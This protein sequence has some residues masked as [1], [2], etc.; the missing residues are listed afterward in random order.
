MNTART[1]ADAGLRRRVMASASWATGQQAM[2]LMSNIAVSVVLA[3]T[4][5][6]GDFGVISLATTL[7]AF[8]ATVAVGGMSALGIKALVDD[9]DAEASTMTGLILL[10]EGFGLLCYLGVVALSVVGGENRVV[11]ATAVASLVLFARAFDP[12]DFWF[13][14]RLNSRRS[15]TVRIIVTVA[16]LAVRI[17][18]AVLGAG[19]WVFLSLFVLE[20][21]VVTGALL[22]RYL[23]EAES[24][25]FARPN[26]AVAAGMLGGS[27]I[28]LLSGIANQINLRADQLIIQSKL[29]SAAVATY[30]V[31]AR[32]SEMSYFL[33]VVFMTATFPVIIGA[34]K[35]WGGD[36]PKYTALVQRSYDRACWAGIGIAAILF[37]AGPFA[38][39]LL[40]GAR[41]SESGD[42]L[43]IHVLALPFVF[44]AAVYSKWI[45]MENLL[46]ASLLRHALGA[47]LNIALN[48][49]LIPMYGLRGAA[50]ATVISYVVASYLACFVGRPMWPAGVAMTKAFLAP[51]RLL[52]RSLAP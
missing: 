28:L 17:L 22:A 23:T 44:M 37:L 5:P 34:R 7:A 42:I 50:I 12:I 38:I 36:N 6:I 15:A 9:Q 20:S 30:A 49:L 25:G 31:A 48:F 4:L 41:F 16:M 47:A 8:G 1:S 2:L 27:W 39:S 51:L 3:R 46:V 35:E 43:R 40:Y 10:R 29:G 13:Q 45:I 32:L 21:L 52:R 14:S 24:P 26:I 11:A 33:P 19:L 18:A